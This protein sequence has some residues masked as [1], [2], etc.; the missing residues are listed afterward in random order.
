MSY[1]FVHAIVGGHVTNVLHE[2]SIPVISNERCASKFPHVISDVHV[3]AW[4]E[5]NQDKAFCNVS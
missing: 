2:V 1:V 3:C 5:V 4:D